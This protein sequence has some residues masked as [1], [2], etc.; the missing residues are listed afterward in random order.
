MVGKSMP[1]GADPCA[2]SGHEAPSEA[3]VVGP[4]Q[5]ALVYK[6]STS[7]PKCQSICICATQE[8]STDDGGSQSPIGLIE[9]GKGSAVVRAEFD[10]RDGAILCIPASNVSL[11]VCNRNGE[12]DPSIEVSA[13]AVAGNSKG[14][15]T[16]SFDIDSEN[17]NVRVPALADKL[18][19]ELAV[20]DAGY[21]AL[22]SDSATGETYGQIAE[23]VVYPLHHRARW[24][25]FM[26]VAPTG[27]IVT[28]FLS[29]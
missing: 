13:F 5:T 1:G 10:V 18:V 16:R 28:F 3:V 26:N 14:A 17:P 8:E 21:R 20:P 24:I 6:S 2:E 11:S 4:G 23:G 15:N 27:G 22:V 9:F 25:R 7:S 12:G 29:I 19:Y